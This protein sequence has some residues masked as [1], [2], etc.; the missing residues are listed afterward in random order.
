MLYKSDQGASKLVDH[1]L[2]LTRTVDMSILVMGF[3][4]NVGG[5][6]DRYR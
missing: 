3:F 6:F 1:D 2:L 4:L 5:H